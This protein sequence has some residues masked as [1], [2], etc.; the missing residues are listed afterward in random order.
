MKKSLDDEFLALLLLHSLPK[1]ETWAR[2]ISNTIEATS[3][4]VPLTVT[5][6]ESC[7]LH[8]ESLLQDDPIH[9]QSTR[10]SSLASPGYPGKNKTILTLHEL[11]E[12]SAQ[13]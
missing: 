7:L 4:T 5:H 13:G 12:G 2:F 3:D 11:Q 6:V 1:M 9:G 8:A 10:Y